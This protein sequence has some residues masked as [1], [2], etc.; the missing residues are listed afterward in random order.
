MFGEREKSK[1]SKNYLLL[2]EDRGFSG[3][4]IR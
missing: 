4:L 2:G 3:S 1:L